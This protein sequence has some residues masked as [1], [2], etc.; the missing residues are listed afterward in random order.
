MHRW[1]MCVLYLGKVSKYSNK[2]EIE[3]GG[4]KDMWYTIEEHT[5]DGCHIF[6]L[7]KD[8]IDPE[9]IWYVYAKTVIEC[10]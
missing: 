2:K 8:V 9:K 5:L 3:T 1:K 4:R 10:W 7:G 6:Y